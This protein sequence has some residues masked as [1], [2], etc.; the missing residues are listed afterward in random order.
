MYTA[1][2]KMKSLSSQ[3]LQATCEMDAEETHK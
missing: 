1:I 3:G 2:N